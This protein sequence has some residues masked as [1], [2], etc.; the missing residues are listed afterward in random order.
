[1]CIIIHTLFEIRGTTRI[2]NIVDFTVL[3]NSCN[4]CAG[5]KIIDVI[6]YRLRNIVIN[7]RLLQSTPRKIDSTVVALACDLDTASNRRVFRLSHALDV[8]TNL[9]RASAAKGEHG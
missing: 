9:G 6:K 1:M 3:D 4:V 7:L 8:T 5:W 2:Q